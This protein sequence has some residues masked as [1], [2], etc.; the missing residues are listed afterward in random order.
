MTGPERWPLEW[1]E[2]QTTESDDRQ[3]RSDPIDVPGSRRIVTLVHVSQR[4]KNHDRCERNVYEKRRSPA[5]V[6][7]QPATDDRAYSRRDGTES[8]PRADRP[9]TLGTVECRAD[10]S[11]TARYQKRGTDSLQGSSDYQEARARRSAAPDRGCCKP[12]NPD[13]ENSFATELVAE[14]SANEDESA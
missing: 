6:L 9:S 10:Y 14:R 2:H 12:N 1:A 3:Q 5:D 7:D 4:E 8:G 11:E 13:K